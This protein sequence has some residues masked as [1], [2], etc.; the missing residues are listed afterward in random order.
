MKK[1]IIYELINISKSFKDG[2]DMALVLNKVNFKAYRGELI[3]IVGPSGSGKS[4][5][6]TILGGLQKP[7]SGTMLINNIDY[8]K[9][10]NKDQSKLRF[11]SI[12]FVLQNSNLI[13]FLTIKN[14]LKLKDKYSH[15]KF[16]VQFA[17]DILKK[18]DIYKISNRYPSE[19]SGGQ[20]QRAA[21][22]SALY[23]DPDIILAD[24]PTA[25]LDSKKACE[26]TQILQT[27]AKTKN[28]LVIMVT[29]DTR[30]LNYFDRVLEIKDGILSEKEFFKSN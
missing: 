6:L 18:L 8:F 24:E 16:D 30:L 28:K 3:A 9:L 17:K 25:S 29:H 1:N 23:N 26:V 5:L 7:T 12:G 11:N 21:I 20:R 10:K 13:P 15:K 2:N 27:I 14:Q 4:T 22:A 19:I